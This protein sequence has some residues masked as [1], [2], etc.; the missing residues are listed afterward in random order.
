MSE[1][2]KAI[3]NDIK[4][5]TSGSLFEKFLDKVDEVYRADFKTSNDTL[6]NPNDLPRQELVDTKYKR[7]KQNAGRP[8]VPDF[9]FTGNAENS[10]YSEKDSEGVSYDYSDSL[11]SSYMN[12]HETVGM[13]GIVRRQFPVEEDS[14]SNRQQANIQK[15]TEAL[16]EILMSK[17]TIVVG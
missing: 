15:V 16:T 5:V 13:Y 10:F 6:M 17:R 2:G 9:Y 12:M 4:N 8:P 1:F 11:V 7:Q 3:S 14:G